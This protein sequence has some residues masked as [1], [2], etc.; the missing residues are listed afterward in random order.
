[1]QCAAKI[2]ARLCQRSGSP[3]QPAGN[4][5]PPDYINFEPMDPGAQRQKRRDIILSSL[6]VAIEASNL[7]KELCSITPA[8][9]VFGSFSVILTMI[10]VDLSTLSVS[11][12]RRLTEYTQ[13]SMANEEDCV[14]LGLA[15]ADVCT[16]L[17]RG[18][19]G[20]LSKDLSES[21]NEAIKQLTM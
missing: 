2:A 4:A 6:N 9:P 10:K 16:A 21:V 15:C 7:A 20:K 11:I 3:S 5:F 14:E 19:N 8:K 12:D 13:E 1:V 17:S 18:L